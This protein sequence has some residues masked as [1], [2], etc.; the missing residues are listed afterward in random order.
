MAV[1][2]KEDIELLG[3]LFEAGKF[4]P[5]IDKTYPLSKTA[6]AL[7]YLKEGHARGKVVVVMP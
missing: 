3:E 2:I 4:V 7:K 5:I 1:V 6:E